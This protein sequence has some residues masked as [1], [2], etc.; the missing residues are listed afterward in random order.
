[1]SRKVGGDAVALTVHPAGFRQRNS[2][3]LSPSDLDVHA[4]PFVGPRVVFALRIE[5][6]AAAVC[7]RS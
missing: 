1:V 2:P 4:G 6:R 7:E 3:E 5:R